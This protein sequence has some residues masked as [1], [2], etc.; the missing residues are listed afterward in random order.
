[1]NVNCKL[2]IVNSKM[3][4]HKPVLLKESIDRLNLKSESIAVD[5]TLG[6][7]GHSIG[8]LNIIGRSGKLIGIDQDA[9]AVENFRQKNSAEQVILVKDNFANLKNVLTDLRIEKVDAI[10][11]DLG[12][13]SMQLED[14]DIGM[15][16]LQ[17]A[18]LDMRLDREGQ[19]S[20]K[21]VVNTYS[22]GELSRL[23]KNFG[24]ER[25]AS[26][27]AKR[28][29]DA[30]KNKEIET[31]TEL[32]TIINTAIPEKFKHGKLHPATKTFQALRI[33]VNHELD[34]LEKF[35]PQAI[36][37]L[38]PGGRLAIISFHSL[39]DRIVKDIFRSHARGCICP[40]DF[41]ICQ[42]G[43]VAKVKIITKKPVEPSVE[44]VAENPRSRSAKLRVCEKL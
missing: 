36:E 22:Q 21:I 33:E 3:V 15:S 19:L 13:S 29:V 1:M 26:L 35:I 41:P 17:D 28:I 40:A 12:Y 14:T 8:M 27:I 4:S 31:T 6:G 43:Q 30:R 2:K 10:L 7:G 44:E 42:C 16:F 38:N 32:V 24:E 34:V 9:V 23:I 11:A 25:F 18:P 39:E 5:A 20:A 37:V